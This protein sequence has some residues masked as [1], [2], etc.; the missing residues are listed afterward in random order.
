M[1][2]IICIKCAGPYTL[3]CC[4]AEHVAVDATLYPTAVNPSVF[5]AIL[6]DA[7]GKDDMDWQLGIDYDYEEDTDG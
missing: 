4:V 2:N 1:S 7:L 3:G 6:D 5:R